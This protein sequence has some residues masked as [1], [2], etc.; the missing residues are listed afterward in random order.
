MFLEISCKSIKI[1]NT[2]YVNGRINNI[3]KIIIFMF[4]MVLYLYILFY[5]KIFDA[6]IHILRIG[7]FS[8]HNIHF[9]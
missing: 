8:I 2:F 1:Q 6:N 7:K 5:Y 3:D 4:Y 9:D